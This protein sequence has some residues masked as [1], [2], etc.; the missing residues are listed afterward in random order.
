MNLRLKGYV[1]KRL[2][3]I[4]PAV[5]CV[6]GHH[7]K[8]V[9]LKTTSNLVDSLA[10]LK[11][12]NRWWVRDEIVKGSRDLVESLICSQVGKGELFVSPTSDKVCRVDKAQITWLLQVISH[13]QLWKMGKRM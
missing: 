8:V 2:P 5:R 12:S 7:H 9:H 1:L 6:P 10:I 3:N 11:P 4:G 13:A